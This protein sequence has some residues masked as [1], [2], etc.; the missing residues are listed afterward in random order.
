MKIVTLTKD[1]TKNILENM[2]KKKSRSVW[3]L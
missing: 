2:L 3:G 1:T